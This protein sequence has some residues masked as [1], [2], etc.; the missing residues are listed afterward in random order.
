M[1]ESHQRNQGKGPSLLTLTL[2]PIRLWSRL[3]DSCLSGPRG[4]LQ[5]FLSR[6]L[7]PGV[8]AVAAVLPPSP[9]PAPRAGN[10]ASPERDLEFCPVS[11]RNL[12]L[13]VPPGPSSPLRVRE[14]WRQR[15]SGGTSKEGWSE[16]VASH[17]AAGVGEGRGAGADRLAAQRLGHVAVALVVAVIHRTGLVL[18]GTRGLQSCGASRG[19]IRPGRAAAGGP[20]PTETSS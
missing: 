8:H 10:F 19:L 13:P 5:S 11:W 15:A 2:A 7:R 18:T 16:V 4:H 1:T 3:P 17:K 6:L 9:A 14:M 12:V 20:Q